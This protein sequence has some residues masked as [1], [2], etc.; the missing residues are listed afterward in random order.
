MNPWSELPS[1]APY[2]LPCDRPRIEEFNRSRQATEIRQLRL[3]V[4]PEP[5]IGSADAPIVLLNINP[6]YTPDDVRFTNDSYARDRWFRN[7]CHEPSDYPFYP[8]DPALS[9][10]PTAH[11]WKRRLRPLIDRIGVEATANG[12]LC[13]EY[14]PYHSYRDPHFPGEIPSQAYSFAIVE[15]AIGRGAMI[16]VM[17]GIRAWRQRLPHLIGYESAYE[18]KN[19]QA[20]Y[21]SPGVFPGP[22]EQIVSQLRVLR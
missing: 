22:F 20:P 18:T 12:L 8:L 17:R 16:L 13:I 6:G 15:R 2:V 7:V 11:W 1:T 10:T 21:V 19:P 14:F 9:W 3:D 4:L 5:Y